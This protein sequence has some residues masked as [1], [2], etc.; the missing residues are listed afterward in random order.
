[1]GK[2]SPYF[3]RQ[4]LPQKKPYSFDQIDAAMCSWEAMLLLREEIPALDE[5]W[6][7][8]GST[9][10]RH[11]AIEVGDIVLQLWDMMDDIDR[12]CFDPFDF[13]FVPAVVRQ[14]DW[15]QTYG[16]EVFDNSLK[17][18]LEMMLKNRTT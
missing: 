3:G 9:I 15:S 14:I 12:N 1:M 5:Q 10:M 8:L 16:T 11:K 4:K 2:C 6:K 13:E 17:V 7:W 18:A